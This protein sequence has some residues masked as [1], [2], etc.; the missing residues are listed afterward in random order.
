MIPNRGKIMD[1]EISSISS[2]ERRD[3]EVKTDEDISCEF[4][5]EDRKF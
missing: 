1:D 3:G 5:V 4:R 2:T